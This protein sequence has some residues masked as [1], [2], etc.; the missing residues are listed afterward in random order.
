M[1]SYIIEAIEVGAL[2][3]ASGCILYLIW[4]SIEDAVD[5]YYSKKRGEIE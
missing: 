5:Y 4:L 3:I 1:L 2:V